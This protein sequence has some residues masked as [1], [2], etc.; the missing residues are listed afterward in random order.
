[1]KKLFSKALL[2]CLL[3]LTALP[4]RMQ[5]AEPVELFELTSYAAIPNLSQCTWDTDIDGRTSRPWS[6]TYSY[7]MYLQLYDINSTEYDEYLLTPNFDLKPGHQYVVEMQPSQF[8]ETIGTK[9]SIDVM[10][11]QGNDART[12]TVLKE[13]RGFGYETT[14]SADKLEKINF[15]VDEEGKYKIALHSLDAARIYN[16]RIMDYGSPTE[17]LA[18]TGLEVTPDPTGALKAT[19]TFTMP[20]KNQGGDDLGDNLTYKIYRLLLGS[21]DSEPMLVQNDNATAGETVT[22]TDDSAPAGT[23]VYYVEALAG[24]E[25]SER[26][27]LS[28]YVGPEEP[29]AA[30]AVTLTHNGTAA[31][32]TWE[33]PTIGVHGITLDPAQLSYD[34]T[35]VLG[36]TETSVATG[37]TETTFTESITSDEL[38]NLTYRVTV[39]YGI[40]TALP[41]TSNAVKLGK[42]QIPFADSFVDGE[43]NAALN[44]CWSVEQVVS[45]NYQW[46]AAEKSIG[47][48]SCTSQDND[49]GLAYYNS[50]YA[51]AGASCRLYTASID[52]NGLTNG[53]LSFWYYKRSGADYI[54]LQYSRDGGEWTTFENGILDATLDEGE[55]EG[56]R[57]YNFSLAEAVAG[58]NDNI[59]IAFTSVAAWSK[60]LAIDNVQI[61]N[62]EGKDLSVES[63]AIPA[64]IYSGN[65]AELS[66]TVA[67]KGAEDAAASDYTLNLIT[68][69]P[70]E[71]VLPENVAIPSLKDQKFTV[72]IPFTAAEVKDIEKYNFKVEVQYEGDGNTENNTSSEV[73]IAPKF[74]VFTDCPPTSD[75]KFAVQDDKSVQLSWKC[76]KDPNEQLLEMKESFEDCADGT[77]DNINGWTILDKDGMAANEPYDAAPTSKLSVT[78]V[79]E[80]GKPYQADGSKVLGVNYRGNVYGDQMDEW[81]ISPALEMNAANKGEFSFLLGAKTTERYAYVYYGYEVYWTDQELDPADPSAAFLGDNDTYRLASNSYINTTSEYNDFYGEK[82]VPVTVPTVP[83]NARYVAVRLHADDY[84]NDIAMWLDDLNLNEKN[85]LNVVGYNVYEEGVGRLNEEI[86]PATTATFTVPALVEEATRSIKDVADD[87]LSEPGA[88]LIP[89]RSFYV[90][91]VYPEGETAPTNIV[92][93]PEAADLKAGALNAPE[94]VKAGEAFHVL[95]AVDNIGNLPSTEATATLFNGTTELATAS[96]PALEAG[97]STTL[98]FTA[99]LPADAPEDNSIF[100]VINY[101][102]DHYA[103][104]NTSATAAVKRQIDD[105][106]ATTITGP[107]EA[108]AGVEF[109]IEVT[110]TNLGNVSAEG[111]LVNLLRGTE[112]IRTATNDLP[113]LAPGE[114]TKVKFTDMFTVRSESPAVYTATVGYSFDSKA[115]NN[116]TAELSVERKP[117]TMEAPTAL[118]ALHGDEGVKLTWT[119]PVNTLP[120]LAGLELTGYRV[121]RDGKE[122]TT[123][124]VTA[125]AY[126]DA[127][128]LADGSYTYTVKAVYNAGESE[129]SAPATVEVS[130][131]GGIYSA[132]ITVIARDGHIAITGADGMEARVLNTAGALLY[133]GNAESLVERSFN[134]GN[135]IVAVARE[136]F[137]VQLR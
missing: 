14:T 122:L 103:D 18:P 47:G 1:M 65:S 3:A 95:F 123:E 127:E 38:V 131:I 27:N 28:A 132:A 89:V 64:E 48:I 4:P 23:V 105:L 126:T 22:W 42:I 11:G 82:M 91:T 49:G 53:V 68:D 16:F 133:R 66:F 41:A 56:W 106:E 67:N 98:D 130:A 24:T 100:A 58:A 113:A 118:A 117:F 135:Y 36:D 96:I 20:S 104:N 110:V 12:F 88:P 61:F 111:Y 34:V 29:N 69:Y 21:G 62:L 74:L 94:M 119:A 19:I 120:E 92:T 93:T 136:V 33:A 5:A 81:V 90:T 43:G 129:L 51:S 102:A 45:S 115:D 59:R 2:F 44:P 60:S 55:E 124:P 30:T 71:I 26:I 83:G 32:L 112:V 57:N 116:S 15:T 10:L 134:V 125:E 8:S 70:G 78:T 46:Q 128:Q 87:N 35:R 7:P 39:K 72:S 86:I 85:T 54:K 40:K 6:M 101:E 9:A 25:A 97:A 73:S 63:I 137:K 114:S 108:D 37:L 52:I 109:E 17:P 121:Y 99:T 80:G 79:A 76:L 84:G 13:L 77:T 31:T 50:C 107:A 75:L